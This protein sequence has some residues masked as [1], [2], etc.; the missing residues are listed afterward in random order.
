VGAADRAVGVST[1]AAKGETKSARRPLPAH[2]PRET[3]K[4]LPKQEARPDCGGELKSLGEDASETLEYVPEHFKVIRQVRPKPA[5]GCCD[6]IRARGSSEPSDRSRHG[7]LGTSGACFGVK[8]L[9]S[10]AV[11]AQASSG[12]TARTLTGKESVELHE[13]A[14]ETDNTRYFSH[15]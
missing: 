5:C 3:R 8:V 15:I 13:H 9:R 1:L 6:K 7:G 10:S 2:L 11:V 12:V 4:I 14:V